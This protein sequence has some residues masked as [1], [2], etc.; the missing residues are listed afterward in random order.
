MRKIITV[1]FICINAYVH[2]QPSAFCQ[3]SLFYKKYKAGD[4]LKIECD[5]VY[6]L[7]RFT[8]QYYQKLY[9]SYKSQDQ[10][11]KSLTSVYD[12][13]TN[14]YEKRI[15]R[16]SAEYDQLR[17]NFDDL[18]A[19]S[20]NF[21]ERADKNLITITNSLTAAD[22]SIQATKTNLALVEQNIKNEI[23]A[24]RK[25]KLRMLGGG[26]AIGVT[27]TALLFILSN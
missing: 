16:Q 7:N 23:K 1:L 12:D 11:I 19:S 15:A 18:S 8:F 14:L 26:F 2:A 21:I 27:A 5:T 22:N 20:Q 9:S 6:M 10:R 17:K 3:E 24:S 4:S 13:M 25:D